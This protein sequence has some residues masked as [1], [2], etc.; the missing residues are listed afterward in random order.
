MVPSS[1]EPFLAK[2]EKKNEGTVH[3]EPFLQLVEIAHVVA[4]LTFLGS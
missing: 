2:G 3:S 1:C 4:R